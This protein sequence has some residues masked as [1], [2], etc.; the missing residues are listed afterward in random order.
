MG[1]KYKISDVQE[2]DKGKFIITLEGQ[3]LADDKKN[4]NKIGWV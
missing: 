1:Q 3:I 2:E 4:P